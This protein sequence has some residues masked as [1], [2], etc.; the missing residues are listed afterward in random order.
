M[1]PTAEPATPGTLHETFE[2]LRTRV[3][4]LRIE[5]LSARKERL[6]QLRRWIH[7]HRPAIQQA[8]FND[9]R[10]PA[11][12]VDGT[13]IFHVLSEIKLA[14]QNLNDWCQSRKVDTP[15]TLIGTRS[16][17]Q[18]EPRGICLIL[19]PWNYPFSLATGPLVSALAAG[20]AVVLKPSELTPHTAALISRMVAEVFDPTT[21]T[22]V[23]GDSTAAQRLLELPFDHIFF[24]GSPAIGKKVMEA[25]SR[26]LA[27]VTLELGGK[28]PTIV[29]AT[30]DIREAARR[31]AVAKFVN[32][33]QTCVAPDYVLA[34]EKIAPAFTAA[35]IEQIQ[36]HFLENA[37]T[38]ADSA[39]YCRIVNNRHFTR[40]EALLAQAVATGA[41]V[42][43]GGNNNAATRFFHPTVLTAIPARTQLMEEEIFGPIL[44]VLSFKTLHEAIKMVN[45]KPKALALYIFSHLKKEQEQVLRQTSAGGVCINECAIHFLNHNLPFGGVNNSGMGKSHG[46]YGFLAFSNEKAVLKQ[47]R[48]FT[49]VQALYPPYTR[50]SRK[51][52]DWILRLF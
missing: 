49:S 52:M 31:I 20:N 47:K 6:R 50:R 44:P 19:S 23:E 4:E 30:A 25:A 22:V 51:L 37:E 39:S 7:T 18:Y 1:Q 36:K 41:Q 3:F 16:Y 12:E 14:L 26:H 43:Y 48:G 27:S 35:L 13:E 33:G 10:K 2:K 8:V 24:T 9:F 15:L 40:L 17:I 45:A 21:V 38:F 42:A 34:D 46:H 5:P 11:A 28:S 32:N 29:T